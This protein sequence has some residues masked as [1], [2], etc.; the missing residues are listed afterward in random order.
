MG[1]AVREGGMRV[2]VSS[3]PAASK[4]ISVAVGC[5]GVGVIGLALDLEGVDDGRGVDGDVGDDGVVA[6]Q[7]DP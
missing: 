1:V 5:G 3:T 7:V 2:P 4:P 6:P